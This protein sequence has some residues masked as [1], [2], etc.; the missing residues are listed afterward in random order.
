MGCGYSIISKKE[1][2][3]FRRAKEAEEPVCAS[4]SDGIIIV[5]PHLPT[6][7]INIDEE[8]NE[9]DEQNKIHNL[10][11]ED[12]FTPKIEIHGP[13][14]SSKSDLSISERNERDPIL[15]S[16]EVS[17]EAS[18]LIES[19]S[20][21]QFLLD[22]PEMRLR[23]RQIF[24]KR[25]I[26]KFRSGSLLKRKKGDENKK[27]QLKTRSR[28][29]SKISRKSSRSKASKISRVSHNS[30]IESNDSSYKMPIIA[31]FISDEAAKHQAISEHDDV[32]EMSDKGN[33]ELLKKKSPYISKTSFNVSIMNSKIVQN[34]PK[35]IIRSPNLKKSCSGS[36]T[37]LEFHNLGSISNELSS[38]IVKNM[39]SGVQKLNRSSSGRVGDMRFRFPPKEAQSLRKSPNILNRS[40]SETT[41]KLL[42]TSKSKF[43]KSKRTAEVYIKEEE[44]VLGKE[45][46]SA[47]KISSL[48]KYRSDSKKA[49][50]G[51]LLKSGGRRGNTI[52]H[53]SNRQH[54]V[55]L[56]Q[57][58]IFKTPK[59]AKQLISFDVGRNGGPVIRT[60]QAPYSPREKLMV[61]LNTIVSQTDHI[62]SPIN[63]GI[64]KM[65]KDIVSKTSPLMLSSQTRG[66][67]VSQTN[68][69]VVS[70]TDPSQE[71]D[72]DR[73][74][75]IFFIGSTGK[76]QHVRSSL[77]NSSKKEPLHESWMEPT[78][79][80]ISKI[81]RMGSPSPNNAPKNSK[82]V[83]RLKTMGGNQFQKS[84]FTPD[85]NN[86]DS[87]SRS[88]TSK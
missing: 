67:R 61:K 25:P 28:K 62:L 65:H 10:I 37:T 21:V 75:N 41:S 86:K 63:Q 83:M 32:S 35:K 48:N 49:F 5:N 4:L 40:D 6:D 23:K 60:T 24:E 73:R 19:K 57:N 76:K 11:D 85:S 44:V 74:K 8:E 45:N 53:V 70:D 39:E 52:I 66:I 81:Q 56:T 80:E 78:K 34:S 30:Q 50:D 3:E 13:K 12:Q 15:V 79:E 55:S 42:T 69:I 1:L 31:K 87:D 38:N 71:E 2:A 9:E 20:G 54:N 16:D 22:H 36:N 33:G 26:N 72:F 29:Y 43:S 14:I 58:Q 7:V 64:A 84:K 17:S 77:Q 88:K 27:N 47:I 18:S 68:K 82:L 59:G 46:D 51:S